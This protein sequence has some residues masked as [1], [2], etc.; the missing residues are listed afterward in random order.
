LLDGGD[1]WAV[2]IPG[3]TYA[4]PPPSLLPFL[5]FAYL[6]E[7]ATQLI[8]VA[9]NVLAALYLIRRLR[10]KPWWL[11]FPPLVLAVVG[12]GSAL[13]LVALLVRG[14]AAA[15]AGAVLGRVYSAVPLLLLGRWRSLL[16]AA[17][18]VVVTAPFLGWD[19]YLGDFSRIMAT[20]RDQSGGGNSA[21]AVPVLIPVAIVGLF[22]LGR[23]KAAWLAVP[24]LWPNAQEY[25]A[26]IALPVAASVPFA[27]LAMATPL[28]PGI[29]AV[30]V[31][32][33]G[34]WDRW[35]DRRA[36]RSGTPATI[37][38]GAG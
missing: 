13:P 37:A 14:G 11:L 30:G 20:L 4:A 5:P 22:L 1:P 21:L 10:L 32:V 9:L 31:F 33:Q 18:V 15:E 6:P 35:R 2:G 8:W 26:V 38:S 19:R 27:S 23:R 24:A 25:Y 7:I 36:A 17:V 34:V 16:L 29:I 3:G 12:G 28:T